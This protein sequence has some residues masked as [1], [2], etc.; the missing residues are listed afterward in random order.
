VT[1]EQ[2]VGITILAFVSV[3]REGVET[4]LFL[5]ALSFTDPSGTI[6]GTIL[7]I[8]T[9]LILSYLMLK[10]I[11]RMNLQRFLKYTSVL[12]VVFAAGL[13]G[14]DVHEL[15]EAGLLPAIVEQVWNINPLVITHPLHEQGVIGS[16]LKALVGYDGNPELLWVIA[17]LGYVR[18]K[19]V[20]KNPRCQ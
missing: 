10:G 20:T 11:Y 18:A 1:T 15:I 19:R 7:G 5:T 9:V 12:L 14:Y 13:F 4:I 3:F 17:Y 8:G 6:I 2:V 16:I